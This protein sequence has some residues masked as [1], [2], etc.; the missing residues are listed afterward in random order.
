MARRVDIDDLIDATDVARVLHL[1]HANSVYLYMRR[2]PDMPRPVV[3][4]GPK[5]AKL[6]LRSEIQAW[7]HRR[8]P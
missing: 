8:H 5:R 1:A 2:Y 7:E 6:W 3:D 4:R